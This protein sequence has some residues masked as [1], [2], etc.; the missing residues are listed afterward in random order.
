MA[1]SEAL[2]MEMAATVG[3]AEKSSAEAQWELSRVVP[4]NTGVR[5]EDWRLYQSSYR[6]T[7][8]GRECA[9]AFWPSSP[10]WGSSVKAQAPPQSSLCARPHRA[11]A[12]TM[13]G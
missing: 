12:A 5:A 6:I 13:Y 10:D 9:H 8:L 3:V 1:G 7:A 2:E 11:W 4:A